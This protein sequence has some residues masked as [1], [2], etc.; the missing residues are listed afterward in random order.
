MTSNTPECNHAAKNGSYHTKN[1]I[2]HTK[3][4][5]MRT[6]I[7]LFAMFLRYKMLQKLKTVQKRT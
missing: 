4:I 6:A 5:E 2:Y 1:E 7:I 3:N